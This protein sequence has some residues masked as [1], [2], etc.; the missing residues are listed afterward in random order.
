MPV[1]GDLVT[2]VTMLGEEYTRA[3]QKTDAHSSGYVDRIRDEQQLS[4]LADKVF[5]YYTRVGD[6][7]ACGTLALLRLEHMYYKHDT[8]TQRLSQQQPNIPTMYEFIAKRKAEVAAEKAAA[9][10]ATAAAAAAAGGADGEAAPGAGAGASAATGAGAG[11]GAAAPANNTASDVRTVSQVQAEIA[12]LYLDDQQYVIP[13]VLVDNGEALLDVRAEIEKLCNFIYDNSDERARARAMLCQI[14]YHA[15]HDRYYEARDLLLVSH[16]QD[17]IQHMDEATQILYNRMIAQLGLCAYRNGLFEAC[18]ALLH[19]LTVGRPKEL[20]AQGLSNQRFQ[21]RDAEREKTERRRQVPYHMHINLELLEA[22]HLISAMILEVPNMA[23]EEHDPTVRRI[24]A[25]FRKHLDIVSSKTFVG[26]PESTRD[27]VITAA[28]AL[29]ECNWRKAYAMLTGL[30]V[31]KLWQGENH[32]LAQIHTQLLERLKVEALRT[33]M[34]TY[35]SHYDSISHEHLCGVFELPSNLV[36]AV[37]SKMMISNALPAAWDQPTA[38]I[39]M[40]KIEPTRLQS[41]ALDFAEKVAVFVDTNE[42]LLSARTGGQYGDD[43]RGSNRWGGRRRTGRSFGYY[44]KRGGRSR[45]GSRRFDSYVAPC[46]LA[47]AVPV[48]TV[49]VL[50]MR[51]HVCMC[52]DSRRRSTST[53]AYDERYGGRRR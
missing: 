19:E 2:F 32:D 39:V 51:V 11:A 36:H 30:S 13:R 3:L 15:M 43:G 17:H 26:P 33:F 8:I 24:S 46:F 16:L 41:L 53:K 47:C 6:T 27:T 20:L 25:T 40:Q 44:S 28:V 22:C 31:W 48:L 1:V 42:R 35:A 7:G 21:D 29:A 10:A 5:Q 37:T 38:T 18:Q 23:A 9:A 14:F 50:T 52:G 45:G 34:L 49:P 4:V 12:E